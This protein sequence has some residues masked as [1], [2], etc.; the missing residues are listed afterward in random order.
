[1]EWETV[2]RCGSPPPQILGFAEIAS[3]L[4][5]SRLLLNFTLQNVPSVTIPKLP[6]SI[7]AAAKSLQSCP[8]LRD[9]ID[10]SS[11]GSPVPGI[12]QARTLAWGAVS[13][14]HWDIIKVTTFI[15]H[16][17][18]L[19]S[20][21]VFHIFTLIFIL[22]PLIS[23]VYSSERSHRLVFLLSWQRNNTFGQRVLLSH[24]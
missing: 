23:W 6:S 20:F 7:A 22:I 10:N 14:I 12:L 16:H 9:P 11:H 3:G 17:S 15:I 24:L 8:T 19:Y 1:M 18:V 4:F 21:S 2:L 5:T 13:F